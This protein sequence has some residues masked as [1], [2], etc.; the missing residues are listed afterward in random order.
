[1]VTVPEATTTI[2]KRSRY[3][4]EAISKKIINYS[5]LA[6]YIKPELETMLGK[7]ISHASILMALQRLSSDIRPRYSSVDVFK[8][9]PSFITHSNLFLVI[10]SSKPKIE[11]ESFDNYFIQLTKGVNETTIASEKEIEK[12]IFSR[13]NRSEIIKYVGDASAITIKLPSEA[14]NRPGIFYFFLKSLAWEGINILQVYST[15]HE[16]TLIVKSENLKNALGIL[17]S[18]FNDWK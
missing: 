15:M 13:V 16:L 2:I 12:Q 7:E 17:Q 10:I 8:T 1:M 5:S 9:P 14:I 3:L 11:I 18:I 6:R 4:S